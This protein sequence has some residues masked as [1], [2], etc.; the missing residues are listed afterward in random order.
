VTP[1]GNDVEFFEGGKGYTNSVVE[2][3]I[4]SWETEE[5]NSTK[6]KSISFNSI[7][8]DNFIVFGEKLDWIHL[9]VEGL[10]VKLLNSLKEEYIPNFIIFEDYNLTDDDRVLI[11]IWIE[12]NNFKK[13]SENG[14]CMLSKIF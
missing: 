11:Q 12:K 5:I 13:H 7:I 6:R 10:D 9:D 8:E 2:R 1:D 4:R 14:I 3:V